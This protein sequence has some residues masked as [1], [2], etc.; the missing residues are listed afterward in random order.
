MAGLCHNIWFAN[1]KAVRHQES[2]AGDTRRCDKKKP[3]KFGA[4]AWSVSRQYGNDFSQ[5]RN[6]AIVKLDEGFI[7]P[8]ATIVP[9]PN[10][11]PDQPA[12]NGPARDKYGPEVPKLRAWMVCAHVGYF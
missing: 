11:T 5:P 10:T 3:P 6:A 4:G 2:G 8:A 7:N 12:Y 9:S 1:P